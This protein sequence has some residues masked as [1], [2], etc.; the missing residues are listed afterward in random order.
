MK[1]ALEMMR[2]AYRMP[3]VCGAMKPPSGYRMKRSSELT[4]VNGGEM[5]CDCS[6]CRI[7]SAI[8]TDENQYLHIEKRYYEQ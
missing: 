4:R 8:S 7:R 3:S 1:I 6:A 5:K 2:E